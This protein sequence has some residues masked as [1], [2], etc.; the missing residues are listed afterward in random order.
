MDEFRATC[1]N[2][3]GFDLSRIEPVDEL[4]REV[5]HLILGEMVG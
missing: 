2:D 5:L 4:D 3:Y 1:F